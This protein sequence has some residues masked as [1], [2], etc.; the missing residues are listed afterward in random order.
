MKSIGISID[1][2]FFIPEKAEWDL[3]HNESLLYL[4]ILWTTRGYLIDEMRLNGLEKTFW[5]D[6]KAKID[7]KTAIP[8]SD[9]LR[10]GVSDSHLFIQNTHRF[11]YAREIWLF[12]QHHDCWQLNGDTIGC[13]NWLT[14]FLKES[15]RNTAIWIKPPE[16]EITDEEIDKSI[17]KQ[18]TIM[19]YADFMS[20]P[21]IGKKDFI[22]FV[23]A[24]RSGC[25]TPPWFDKDFLK[26]LRG[27]NLE[28]EEVQHMP[29]W[30]ALKPR[31]FSI[32][33]IRE[34]QNEIAKMMELHREKKAVA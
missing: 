28:L 2:D 8:L 32:A 21:P 20:A 3:G 14:A 18:V 5:N 30:N 25:W 16:T 15:D 11:P 6:L 19:A 4:N 29:E 31:K 33:K 24:C 12:D 13:H 1:W 22:A 7:L 34:Y 17:R 10:L 23:H 26:F 9:K 27:P